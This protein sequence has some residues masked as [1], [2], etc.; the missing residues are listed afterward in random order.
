MSPVKEP[1]IVAEM[2]RPETALEARERKALASRTRRESQTF[3]NL[4][5]A[6]VASLAV[7]A[8]IVL[9]VVRPA[10]PPR[11]AVDY[12]A[13]AAEAHAPV[14]LAVPD[15]PSTWGSNS[16][17]YDEAA[18]DGVA[19]WYTGF[20]TPSQQ[21]IALRQGINANPTWLANQLAGSKSTGSTTVEG[22]EWTVYDRRGN[23]KAGNL[24][25]AM[26]SVGAK[27]TYFLFGTGT[28]SEFETIAKDLSAIV[29]A[30][31]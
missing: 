23:D 15:L 21:F 26:S 10:S 24:E 4:A 11:P 16:A 30:D 20:I 22:V 28:Q 1:R 9:V 3:V 29:T 8:V 19:N 27:S 6:L 7:V 25:Y 14:P 2:G 31:R 12:R 13:V 5:T 17:I 18:S